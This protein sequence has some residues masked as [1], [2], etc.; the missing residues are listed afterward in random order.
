MRVS[1]TNDPIAD[2]VAAGGKQAGRLRLG[3]VV[4]ISCLKSTQTDS[5]VQSGHA[6]RMMRLALTVSALSVVDSRPEAQGYCV[7][8]A[9][10]K[11]SMLVHAHRARLSGRKESNHPAIVLAHEI[12]ETF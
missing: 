6:E 8:V 9:E 1:S 10:M 11:A 3:H 12:L 7:F 5:V 4:V 2:D